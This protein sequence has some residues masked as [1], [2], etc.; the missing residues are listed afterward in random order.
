MNNEKLNLTAA[1]FILAFSLVLPDVCRGQVG[2]PLSGEVWS[3]LIEDASGD[4]TR[5]RP[6][7]VVLIYADDLGY[8][9]LSC[10]GATKIKT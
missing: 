6:K 10:Y 7:A 9:D 5:D 2:T 8:G 3:A 1:G 4:A